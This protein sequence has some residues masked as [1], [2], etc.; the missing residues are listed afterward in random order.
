MPAA[1]SSTT[2][3]FGS[4]TATDWLKSWLKPESTSRARLNRTPSG[5]VDE[6][7]FNVRLCEVS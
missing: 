4:A 6:G 7:L 1:G 5:P 3:S 2:C